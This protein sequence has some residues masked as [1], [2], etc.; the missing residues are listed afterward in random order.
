DLLGVSEG[1]QVLRLGRSLEVLED[2]AAIPFTVQQLGLARQDLLIDEPTHP[3][4]Q[5][6]HFVGKPV[7]HQ[8]PPFSDRSRYS[9]DWRSPAS[10]PLPRAAPG[11]T[12]R[13]GR[14]NR[15]PQE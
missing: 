13:G 12:P 7:I 3:A 5:I 8:Q 14:R 10:A 15:P 2:G 9:L 6:A 4:P 11:S 1:P